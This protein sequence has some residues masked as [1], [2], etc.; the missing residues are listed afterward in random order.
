MKKGEWKISLG[1][2]RRRKEDDIKTGFLEIV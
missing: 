2:T 1:I